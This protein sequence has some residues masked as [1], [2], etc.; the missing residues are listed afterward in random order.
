MQALVSIVTPVHNSER[1][2]ESCI[3]SVQAQT[4]PN[5]EHIL[6]DDCSTDR[7]AE[8]IK[9]HAE[10]ETR[11]KYIG[12]EVNS[13]AGVARN[14]A[15]RA[16]SGN[17]I[18]FLDSDD[19]WHPTKLERQLAFMTANNHHFT[20]TAYDKID[21]NGN[22]LQKKVTIKPRVTHHTALYKNPI[23][24]LTVIYDVGFFGKQYMP[25]IRK[26]QDYALWLK[27]LKKTDAFGLDEVLSSYRTGNTSISSNKMDLIKY[28]WKIYREEEGLSFG[29]SLFYLL[30]AIIL[31]M[32][33]YF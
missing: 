8:I 21:E 5:W 1:Y 28:E 6:V 13:G 3:Q 4:Y 23:G 16:A 15:I 29:K 27:L 25:K 32:K 17:Y 26:R 19:L 18:A 22:P 31:K 30:S 24:C 7:S 12:L 20:F 9:A 14:T 11:V 10:N 2:V 33:S